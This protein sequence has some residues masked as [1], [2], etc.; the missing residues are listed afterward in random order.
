MKPIASDR[1]TEM[2]DIITCLKKVQDR[3]FTDQ[4]QAK[5][6]YLYCLDNNRIYYPEDIIVVNYYRFEG[7]SNPDDMAILYAIATFDGRK[8]TLIDAYGYYA[9]EEVGDFMIAVENIH[10]K[11][12]T[13]N[14]QPVVP[15]E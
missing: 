6:N 5:G 11:M 8:G 9:C 7:P 2:P 15:V 14:W 1:L 4:F 13:H 10:K 12:P 3:G